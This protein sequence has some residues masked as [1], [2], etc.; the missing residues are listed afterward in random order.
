V[1]MNRDPPVV[2][3]DGPV[4]FD[5]VVIFFVRPCMHICRMVF[6]VE[7]VALLEVR[8]MSSY[9]SRMVI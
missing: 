8:S 6:A 1:V 9:G 5:P 2:L 7:G 3:P 4:I